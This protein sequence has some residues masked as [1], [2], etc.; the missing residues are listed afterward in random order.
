MTEKTTEATPK[1]DAVA[2]KAAT[3]KVVAVASNETAKPAAAAKPAARTE[4]K[5]E[6]PA[7]P[8]TTA[9]AVKKAAPAKKAA[10]PKAA[11]AKAS[12]KKTAAAP[13]APVKKAAPARKPAV[14]AK[15]AAPKAT[16]PKAVPAKVAKPV[17][18]A[19]PAELLSTDLFT[20][21][22]EGIDVVAE[23]NRTAVETAL[24]LQET[25]STF[26]QG[27]MAANAAI[28]DRIGNADGVTDLATVQREYAENALEAW[29]THMD[30]VST[31][32]QDV[33]SRSVALATKRMNEASAQFRDARWF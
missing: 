31:A 9:A 30:V 33:M 11:T 12:P 21:V 20:V 8:A 14:A 24:Q 5:V 19:A 17:L 23:T 22:R 13:K 27:R 7:M 2:P 10:A 1:A 25:T 29:T 32:C 3:P 18:A 28:V 16:A 15:A 4:A 26:V 6:A